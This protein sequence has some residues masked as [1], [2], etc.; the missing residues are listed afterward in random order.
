MLKGCGVCRSLFFYW[1]RPFPGEGTASACG[2]SMTG[3]RT[4]TEPAAELIVSKVKGW[5]GGIQAISNR[6]QSPAQTFEDRTPTSI[7][8]G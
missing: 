2:K 8:I 4:Q 7:R 3:Q 5:N 1:M 6:R